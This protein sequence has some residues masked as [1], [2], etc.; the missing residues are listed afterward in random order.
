MYG[1]PNGPSSG[2]PLTAADPAAFRSV[3]ARFAT[4]VV[5][6]AAA[7]PGTGRPV[8]LVANSFTSVSL[9]PPLIAFCVAHTSTT[10]P[11]LRDADLLCVSILGEAQLEVSERLALRGG[12]K[13]AGI[14]WT[15]SP[16]GAPMIDDAIAWIECAVEQEHVAGDHMIVVARVLD[17]AEHHEGAPLVFY[18]SSY[19]TFS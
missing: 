6:V 9:D 1:S 5:A 10:W 17:L 11:R 13:F 15:A 4:G 18:R 8:G 7:E 2:R 16:G 14:G 12:D 3:L 19:G